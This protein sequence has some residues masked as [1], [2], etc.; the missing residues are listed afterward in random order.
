ML[1]TI[2]RWV[3]RLQGVHGETFISFR[4]WMT[5]IYAHFK[6]QRVLEFGPGWS[7][8]VGVEHSSATI[9]SIEES[10]EWYEKYRDKFPAERVQVLHRT[11]AWDL[12]ELKELGGPFDFI[13]V[14]G[15]RRT[16]ELLAVQSLL[17]ERGLVGL[18]DAHREDYEPGIRA[19]AHNFFPE[20]H[21]C[22]L[23]DNAQAIAEVRQI[24]PTDY[25][26]KCKYCSPP[27]RRAYFAQF[28]PEVPSE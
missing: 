11:G 26:C 18:H 27:A 9:V 23:S 5:A 3:R 25:S 21:G 8:R 15:G 16:E 1:A 12:G 2:S 13:F 22:V 7:T 4:P 14:D 19:Y 24:V 10:P 20:R 28:M 17:S 6:P